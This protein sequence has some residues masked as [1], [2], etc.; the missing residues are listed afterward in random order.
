MLL[1]APNGCAVDACEGAVPLLMA[2]GWRIA[3]PDEARPLPDLSALTVAQLRVLC[4]ER[5]IDAPKRA[6]KAQLAALLTE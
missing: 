1:T 3:A 5:G 4:D 6:T 2:A